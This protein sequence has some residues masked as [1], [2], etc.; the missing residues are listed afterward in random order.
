MIY[1]INYPDIDKKKW[2]QCIN[3]SPNGLTYCYSWYLDI[4]AE[5]W[6]ALVN[7]DYSQIFPIVYNRKLGIKY[8]YNP[9]FTQQLGLFSKNNISQNDIFSFL[10]AIP[11]SF[12]YGDLNLNTDNNITEHPEYKI[13]NNTTCHLRVNND[14]AIN[15]KNYS[16]NTKRNIK[17]AISNNI[18]IVENIPPEDIITLF[19]KNKGITIPNLKEKDFLIL[20]KL[21]Q[22]CINKKLVKCW[23]AF[24]KYNELCAGAFFL[25]SK[26]KSVFLFSGLNEQGKQN[27]AMPYLI[28]KYLESI[29]GKIE[30][31]DFEGS[32][33]SNLTRFYKSFGSE[34]RTYQRITIN[35]IPFILK[36]WF[37]LYKYLR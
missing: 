29:S 24:T 16:D 7:D 28:D 14:I 12:C 36:P 33:N 35:H 22:L 4:V 19:R 10:N 15:R 13:F 30:I 1:Y 27:G 37:Y 31:F 5:N 8:I 18:K 20:K 25:I 2:D 6:D 3:E 9:P 32:N 26:N 34:V 17:K 21:M 23:G 11:H